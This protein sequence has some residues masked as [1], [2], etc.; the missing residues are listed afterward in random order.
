MNTSII[1]KDISLLF[2]TF[3]QKAINA[4][5]MPTSSKEILNRIALTSPVFADFFFFLTSV[6]LMDYFYL[7]YLFFEE[8]SLFFLLQLL[9]I[10]S[11]I[12]SS[13]LHA[14]IS[15]YIITL[16]FRCLRFNFEL[17]GNSTIMGAKVNF[18]ID[19]TNGQI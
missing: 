19:S 9:A 18:L 12:S 5:I 7:S 15:L 13:F 11:Q 1:H 2:F 16:F 4:K 3:R 8:F 10:D 17:I 14:F 6:T